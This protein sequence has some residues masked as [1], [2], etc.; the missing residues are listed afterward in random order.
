MAV[1]K[2]IVVVDASTGEIYG[3]KP[4]KIKRLEPFFMTTQQASIELS[5]LKLTAMEYRIVHYLQGIADYDN[6][7]HVSQAFLAKELE[8]TEATISIS[9]KRLSELNVVKRDEVC[10]RKVFIISSN[11]STRGRVK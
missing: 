4:R 1:Q 7:A 8:T 6:V 10:G 11:V 5:K 3:T 9:L 2:E